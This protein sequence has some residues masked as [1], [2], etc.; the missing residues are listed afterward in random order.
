MRYYSVEYGLEWM[1]MDENGLISRPSIKMPA[2]GK[3]RIL[4]AV[5]FNNFG[6]VVQCFG[7]DDIKAGTI[8]W[9]RKNG[10][11]RVHVID[12][13]HGTRRIWMNPTHRIL[14]GAQDNA[15]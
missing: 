8:K 14:P 6:R 13:D 2:S 15:N 1:R 12:L 7:L 9:K 11:Q 5:R 3:W 4:G 10:K